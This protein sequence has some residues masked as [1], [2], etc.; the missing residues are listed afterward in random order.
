MRRMCARIVSK[1]IPNEKEEI[2]LFLDGLVEPGFLHHVRD[3]L[4][5]CALVVARKVE[6]D[7][8]RGHLAPV[9]SAEL[10]EARSDRYADVLRGVVWVRHGD[11]DVGREIAAV[12][13][14]REGLVHVE[15]DVVDV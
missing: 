4:H 1:F 13:L 6:D 5:D 11:V 3:M 14:G 12:E 7:A 9:L 2:G 15:R 8:E 10:S